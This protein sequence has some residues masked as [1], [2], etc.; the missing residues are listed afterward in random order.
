MQ[1]G[2]IVVSVDGKAIGGN[3]TTLTTEIQRHPDQPVTVVVDRDGTRHTLT[4][5]PANGR[6]E[7]E[8]GSV[9]PAGTAP[10]GLIG[11]SLGS[12]VQTRSPLGAIAS[13][14]SE[15]GTV[16]WA[17]VN[18]IGHLFSPGGIS[19]RFEQVTSAKA[20]AQAAANGTR[21][22]SI[23][24]IGQ[25][26]TDALQAGIGAYLYI[27][28]VINIFFGVFNLFPMLP[29]DGGHVAI[30]VYEKI[31]TGRRKVLYHAD[32]AK[33]MPFTWAFMLFLVVLIV[34]ALLTD[35]LH[36]MANPFG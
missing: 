14:G 8:S 7:H 24:G 15:L 32:V 21:A 4:V 23:V 2:D 19:Q 31:R 17:S 26:A 1:P 6:V 29:L 22:Q 18:G 13:T 9:A 30:A 10:Y 27:L 34:P 12:P 16:A 11:V 36:P 33:L 25:T 35:I 5:T 28:I 20:A 3:V